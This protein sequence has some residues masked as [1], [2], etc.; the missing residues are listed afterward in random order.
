MVNY[1]KKQFLKTVGMLQCKRNTIVVRKQH[2]GLA[3]MADSKR[4]R[5]RSA[6]SFVRVR[7]RFLLENRADMAVRIC[8]ACCRHLAGRMRRCVTER[9]AG[10]TPA[11]P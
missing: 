2:S 6:D 10:E 7:R 8:L 1:L 11:A 9:P 5:E 3:L 4:G